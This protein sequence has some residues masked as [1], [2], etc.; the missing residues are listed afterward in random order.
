MRNKHLPFSAPKRRS[1]PTVTGNDVVDTLAHWKA[2]LSPV[3]KNSLPAPTP[4]NF[5]VTSARGGLKL[6]WSPVQTPSDTALGS[7]DGYEIL[8][9]ASGTFTDDLE[10]IPITNAAQSSYFD[11]TVGATRFSYR[12]RTTSGTRAN[13]QSMR[14]PE[15]GIVSH[16]SI[17]VNDTRTASTT[18]ADRYTTSKTRSLARFGNY[19][20]ESAYKTPLGQVGGPSR[21]SGVVPGTSP[22]VPAVPTVTFDQ[23]GSGENLSAQMVVGGGASIDVDPA[24]P[25]VIDATNL[26]TTPVSPT[27]PALGQ[28][29]VLDATGTL[30]PMTLW[31]TVKLNGIPISDDYDVYVNAQSN[32]ESRVAAFNVNRP[33]QPARN[34]SVQVNGFPVSDDYEVSVNVSKKILVNGV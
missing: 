15:S 27:A 21:A 9:S 10:V 17:D 5:S 18:L 26:Q 7:P 32:L 30:V 12:I 8:K 2:K 34:V 6:S 20:L 33:V 24:D 25:G 22:S 14:G 31:S 1:L 23:I 3:V 16:T 4:Y 13:P 11:S 28:L 29:F 19:G